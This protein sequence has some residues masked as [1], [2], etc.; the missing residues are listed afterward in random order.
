LTARRIGH[1]KK[2]ILKATEADSKQV[3]TN[4]QPIKEAIARLSPFPPLPLHPLPLSP[5]HA[6][7]PL[8]RSL[9]LSRVGKT[10]G[11]PDPATWY[12]SLRAIHCTSRSRS[13]TQPDLG[14]SQW[15]R[16]KRTAISHFPLSLSISQHSRQSKCRILNVVSVTTTDGEHLDKQ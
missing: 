10:Q 16:Y 12:D 14:S 3:P 11:Q 4:W 5:P 6:S 1:S 15:S 2:G 13:R 7:A 8:Y 9:E